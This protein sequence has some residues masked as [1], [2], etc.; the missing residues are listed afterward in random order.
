MLFC[1]KVEGLSIL[2]IFKKFFKKDQP[3]ILYL[4]NVVYIVFK[5]LKILAKA[6]GHFL[7]LRLIFFVVHVVEFVTLNW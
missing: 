2:Y 5:L 4:L 7:K 3:S 1:I 6:D